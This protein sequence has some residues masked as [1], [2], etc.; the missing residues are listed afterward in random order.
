MR[1]L[2]HALLSC[3]LWGISTAVLYPQA[4]APSAPPKNLVPNGGFE[5]VTTFQNLYDGVDSNG[6]LKVPRSNAP[7][8]LEGAFLTPYPFAASVSVADVNGD[9]LPD[10]VVSS[11]L[12]FLYWFPNVGKRK[13]PAFHHGHLVQTFL[14]TAARVNIGDWNGDGKPDIIFGNVDGKVYVLLNQG[15]SD[16]PRWVSTMGKPRWFLPRLAFDPSVPQ[17]GYEPLIVQV[18]ADPL[19]VGN[20]SAPVFVDWNN[21]GLPDLIVGEGSYSANNV[22]VWLNSGTKSNPVFKADSKFCLARGQ[23]REL[24]SP[25]VYDWNGDG[26]PDLLVGGRDGRVALY[27]GTEASRKDPKKAGPL[28]FTKFITAGGQEHFGSMVSVCACD[29]NE[30]GISDL[31]YGTASGFLYVALGK[32][33]REDPELDSPT[34]IQGVDSAGDFDQ[35][36]DWRNHYLIGCVE[37]GL[38]YTGTAP[39]PVVLSKDDHPSLDVKEGKRIFYLSW[40]EKFYGWFYKFYGWIRSYHVN[41]PGS[42]LG[43]NEG[44]YGMQVTISPFILGQKYELSFW[45]K[46]SEMKLMYQIGYQQEIQSPKNLKGAPLHPESFYENVVLLVDTWTQ[47]HKTYR[48]EGY[49]DKEINTNGRKFNRATLTFVFFG[50]GEA[51]LDDVKLI[52]VTK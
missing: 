24:L 25:S 4:P 46:G 40:F 30:D 43:Y 18:G 37:D 45:G 5:E 23:G 27:L 13:E 15:S 32:G 7:I 36:R 31:V 35:P 34:Y 10:L 26:I 38:P 6:H 22:Y 14:G 47:Y 48:L 29:Y 17:Q 44:V 28:S 12:G 41:S 33:K 51:W 20:Y 9:G 52:E 49:K 16:A 2:K 21:D 42:P 39:L 3:I 19:S 8:F 11:P 1:V 50:K